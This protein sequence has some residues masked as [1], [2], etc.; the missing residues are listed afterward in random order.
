ME[1]DCTAPWTLIGHG[2]GDKGQ[3]RHVCLSAQEKKAG[4]NIPC[5]LQNEHINKLIKLLQQAGITDTPQGWL[6][7]T[8]ALRDSQQWSR[9]TMDTKRMLESRSTQST[10]GFIQ[11][12]GPHFLHSSVLGRHKGLCGTFWR[13]ILTTCALDGNVAVLLNCKLWARVF[14]GQRYQ[15]RR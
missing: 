1:M 2:A 9:T 7:H 3:S 12:P 11:S 14:G 13:L 10:A 4:S 15:A 8:Q 6:A 5:D